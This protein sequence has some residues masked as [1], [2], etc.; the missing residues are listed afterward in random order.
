ME[1]TVQE[2]KHQIAVFK[3]K[4]NVL[5]DTIEVSVKLNEITTSIPF[6][7]MREV[8]VLWVKLTKIGWLNL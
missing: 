6:A 2:L 7:K 4:V 5:E 3:G 8:L 1:N